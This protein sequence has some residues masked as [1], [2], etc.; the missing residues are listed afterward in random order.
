MGSR[1]FFYVINAN[2]ARFE[3]VEASLIKEASRHSAPLQII[4]TNSDGDGKDKANTLAAVIR[5]QFPALTIHQACSVT[6]RKR[7]GQTVDAF[8]RDEVLASYLEQSQSF[9]RQ[10]LGVVTCRKVRR[11]LVELRDRVVEKIKASSLNVFN[12]SDFDPDQMLAMPDL[13]QKFSEYDFFR[14]YLSSFGFKSGDEYPYE[15]LQAVSASFEKIGSSSTAKFERLG[16]QL[17]SGTFGQKVSALF[18]MGKIAVTLK[19]TL[20]DIFGNAINECI[21][22]VDRFEA[23]CKRDDESFNA[24]SRATPVVGSMFGMR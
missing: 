15:L 7:G 6:A 21:E 24:I 10:R 18:N 3:D 2:S 8:G 5:R 14:D 20:A 9:L 23:H 17:E 13:E 22:E 16:E 19:S 4:L 11:S 1:F 12:V